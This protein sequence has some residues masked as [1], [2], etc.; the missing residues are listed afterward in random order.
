MNEFII[1]VGIVSVLAF[2]LHAAEKNRILNGGKKYPTVLMIIMAVIAPFGSL[3]GMLICG[4]RLKQSFMVIM[5]PVLLALF[6]LGVYLLRGEI[7]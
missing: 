3:M 6:L 1:A 5:V 2:L 4:N 7:A